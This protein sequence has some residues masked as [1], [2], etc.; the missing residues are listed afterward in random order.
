MVMMIAGCRN[1]ARRIFEKYD[2]VLYRPPPEL[3]GKTH[4]AIRKRLASDNCTDFRDMANS[5]EEENI[6]MGDRFVNRR[7]CFV[8]YS[9]GAQE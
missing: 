3:V 6:T 7:I 4:K 2:E 5:T 9:T 1:L 8:N